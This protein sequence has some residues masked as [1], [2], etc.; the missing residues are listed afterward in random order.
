MKNDRDW[1]LGAEVTQNASLLEGLG[2]N[3]ARFFWRQ[4]GKHKSSSER[5]SPKKA[6]E[7]ETGR[8]GKN[9]RSVIEKTRR[10][11]QNSLM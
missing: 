6:W 1:G 8:N 2:E 4:R 7:N 11:N 9:T 3:Y 5:W 10:A